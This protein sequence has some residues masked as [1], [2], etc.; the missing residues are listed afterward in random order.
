MSLSQDIQ[1][2]EDIRPHFERALASANGIRIS[3]RSPGQAVH[4]RQR[5]YKLRALDRKRSFEIYEPGHEMRG[6]SV[7]ENVEIV[8]DGESV[9]IR[10]IEPVKVEDL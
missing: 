5:L 10:P 2:Y 6:R 3:T 4:L 8:L 1:T 7:Y 9:M